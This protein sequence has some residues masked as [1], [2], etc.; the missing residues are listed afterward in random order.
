MTKIAVG[1][2]K[3]IKAFPHPEAK[4]DSFKILELKEALFRE[5]DSDAHCILYVDKDKLTQPR[6][7]KA[8]ARNYNGTL[9]LH[10]LFADIDNPQHQKWTEETL[11]EHKRYLQETGIL[12]GYGYYYTSKGF[13]AFQVLELPVSVFTAEYFI[14]QWLLDLERKGLNVD[15][16]CRDWTRLFRL[17]NVY[18]EGKPYKSELI[19]VEKLIPLH[20]DNLDLIT[21]NVIKEYDVRDDKI[22]YDINLEWKESL[23]QKQIDICKSISKE[24]VR[25]NDPWHS[26]YL[27]IAGAL[28]SRGIS[29]ELL[30]EFCKTIAIISN[31]SRIEDRIACGKTTA[32]KRAAGSPT[33]GLTFLYRTYPSLADAIDI[34]FGVKKQEI[35]SGSDEQDWAFEDIKEKIRTAPN[36][37]TI[38][39]CPPGTGKSRGSIEVAIERSQTEDK[40]ALSV[41]KNRLAKQFQDDVRL[42]GGDA[43]RI[44]GALS[45]K[46]KKGEP[47]CIHHEV[48]SALA[49]GGQ[50]ILYELC[51]GRNHEQCEMY[52]SCEARKGFDGQ[53][54]SSIIISNHNKISQ[55][56]Q[57]IGKKG[58]LVIDEPK[59]FVISYHLSKKDIEMIRIRMNDFE[60]NYIQHM[61]VY[62]NR[63]IEW[64][65]QN[66]SFKDLTNDIDLSPIIDLKTRH[67][68]GVPPIKH[69]KVIQLRKSKQES[70]EIGKT[71]KLIYILYRA[72]V[73]KSIVTLSEKGIDITLYDPNMKEALEREGPVIITD[74]NS[75]LY[76]DRIEAIT[77]NK[78]EYYEYTIK[79]NTTE[80]TIIQVKG[81]NR[82]NWIYRDKIYFDN[83]IKDCFNW[84]MEWYDDCCKKSKVPFST[85]KLGIITYKIIEDAILG[86]NEKIPSSFL[87]LNPST[88]HY[89]NVR[90]MNDLMSLD[91]LV[92]LGDPWKNRDSI[93]KEIEFYGIDKSKSNETE[94]EECKAELEQCHGRLRPTRRT[95]KGYS[96][97]V[98]SVKPGGYGWNKSM[99]KNKPRIGMSTLKP[100][101]IREYLSN[102]VMKQSE[103]A[104]KIEI[105]ESTLTKFLQGKSRIS[106]VHAERFNKLKNVI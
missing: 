5:Y 66:L 90:G 79:D 70:E 38:I 40:T 73:E 6:I 102:N 65:D 34:A 86:R 32:I 39:K 13:R 41:D 103:L 51:Q 7:Q 100:E 44:Y 27:S 21:D 19:S 83:G 8:H 77:G 36:G 74:A 99:I 96:L 23:D 92:T 60:Y 37:I 81:A 17:P 52:E 105:D 95:K 42:F 78:P 43:Y 71:S 98:G 82:S 76:R 45:L 14:Y 48:A 4:L 87:D 25:I 10:C 64:E 59:S 30:P 72:K 58:T 15:L 69:E 62:L 49:D 46:D 55:L 22:L 80:R 20:L 88:G 91:C 33:R 57:H 50:S 101:A 12:N 56:I 11:T 3:Y 54:N 2:D 18:R 63:L 1:K 75:N 67:R 97:H 29:P 106:I 24:L 53:E 61:K 68:I 93:S 47:V 89:Q 85:L 9:E 84:I 28:H 35:G 94:I 16:N 26:I 104:R 31:D